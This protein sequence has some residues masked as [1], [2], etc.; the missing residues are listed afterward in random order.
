MKS[1][2]F[3][4]LAATAIALTVLTLVLI[5]GAVRAWESDQETSAVRGRL[6]DAGAWM[7][8]SIV[9]GNP[10]VPAAWCQAA[11][12]RIEWLDAGGQVLASCDDT[13]TEDARQIAVT[14]PISRDG[15]G[16]LRLSAPPERNTGIDRLRLEIASIALA[17]AIFALVVAYHVTHS[18]TR[19]V[20][21]LKLYAETLLDGPATEDG[22]RVSNDEL[23]TLEE[24]LT[25]L[26]VQLRELFERWRV[27]SSR[28]EAILSGMAEGVLAVD[29]DLRVVFSNQAVTR[30][31]GTR[32]SVR[33]RIPVLEL[34]R[35]SELAGIL[36]RVVVSGE[37]VKQNVTIAAA[38]GRVFEI[39]AA[40]FGVA[41]GSGA[42]AIF[43]DMTDLERLE[44]VR[45]DFVANVSHEMRTPLAAIVGYS[46]TLLDG[47]LEDSEHNRRFVEIIRANA[48]RLNSIA[49]DL[50]VLSEL[51]S[52][53]NPGEPEEISVR[54][55][56]ESAMSTVEP[57][58]RN[59]RVQVFRGDI[60]DARVAG[61][62]FRLE[63]AMSNLLVNAVKFNRE[64]GE[65][66][67]EAL[68]G[69]DGEIRIAVADTGVGIPSQDLPRIFE[70]FYRVDKARSRQVGGTGLGLSIVRH[71][72]ER[73]H[74]RI[75]VQSQ[76][77]RGSTFTVILPTC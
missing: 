20:T 59:R 6:I 71:V 36:K 57:E 41:G 56:L 28:S 9:P 32:R 19:R 63:Q 29:H 74:G 50:L 73:M 15:A 45:K 18:L 16:T 5:D 44:Q 40:P 31:L 48:I 39:Q 46:E 75:E 8:T 2:L 26:G 7:R 21:Q 42:L 68:H 61:H 65:V 72:I 52:G 64:G 27:E 13:G 33:E 77:G 1:P 69:T 24:A 11:R 53:D 17:A 67:V 66:R 25:R 4:R 35:D 49:S 38:G 37:V 14:V 47:G 34:V 30:A 43:Y 10:A 22:T 54:D 60:Q 70:R 12:A 23:G 55:T 76:L 62:R 58:A 51:E 3:R